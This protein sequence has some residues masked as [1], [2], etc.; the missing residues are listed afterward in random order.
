M[1]AGFEGH[2]QGGPP[3]LIPGI[4]DGMDFRVGAAHSFMVAFA[5]KGGIFYHHG[6]HHGIGGGVSATSGRKAQGDVHE[7]SVV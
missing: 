4:I 7:M 5:H 3:G 6:P 2:I 1:V